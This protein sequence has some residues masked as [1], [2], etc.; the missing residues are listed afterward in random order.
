MSKGG[1]FNS[2]LTSFSGQFGRPNSIATSTLLLQK[3]YL[4]IGA[5]W[6]GRDLLSTMEIEYAGR[7]FD[8]ERGPLRQGFQVSDR[9]H[10]IYA[11]TVTLHGQKEG[12]GIVGNHLYNE[13]V[14][15]ES[16]VRE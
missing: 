9:R 13:P 3:P 11:S 8:A 1:F 6:S 12:L 5:C 2:N 7:V 15:V 10:H 14:G 4:T 16:K